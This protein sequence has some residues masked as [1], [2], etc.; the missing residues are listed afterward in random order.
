M[1]TLL[2]TEYT[3][4]MTVYEERHVFIDSS[5]SDAIVLKGE[6]NKK[7]TSSS[8]TTTAVPDK[9][10]NHNKGG[11]KIIIVIDSLPSP[12]EESNVLLISTVITPN[13]REE[14]SRDVSAHQQ[15]ELHAVVNNE[16]DTQNIFCQNDW[17]E[18]QLLSDIDFSTELGTQTSLKVQNPAKH[19]RCMTNY[20]PESVKVVASKRVVNKMIMNVECYRASS[21]L[22][23]Q[24]EAT[25][26]LYESYRAKY[27]AKNRPVVIEEDVYE[28]RRLEEINALIC[29]IRK[30][31]IV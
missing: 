29:E 10:I 13:S 18:S 23:A 8:Q 26:A 12:R 16:S 6:N 11:D 21:A 1:N 2:G 4:N 19:I 31:Q 28:K 25:N 14:E 9:L 7:E 17:F 20:P 5:D 30:D 24:L 15:Q 3:Q 22:Q 27:Q